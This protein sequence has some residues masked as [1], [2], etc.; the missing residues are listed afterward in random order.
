MN[1]ILEF[2]GPD[3]PLGHHQYPG[4]FWLA[5]SQVFKLMDGVQES[6]AGR[7]CLLHMSP[8]SQAEICKTTTT[9]FILDLDT[10]STRVRERQTVPNGNQKTRY[11]SEPT[12]P[13][14]WSD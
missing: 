7:I 4:D 12:H 13:G 6:L 14:I 1:E 8:M 11:T 9:P 2:K 3:P 5:G 10:L